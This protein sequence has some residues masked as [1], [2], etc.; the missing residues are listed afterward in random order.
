MIDRYIHDSP[1]WVL[2]MS[3]CMHVFV[4]MCVCIY[5]EKERGTCIKRENEASE[6]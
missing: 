3:V 4:S 5:R 6:E 2:N 1:T